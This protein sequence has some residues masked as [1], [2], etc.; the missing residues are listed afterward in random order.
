MTLPDDRPHRHFLEA[1]LDGDRARGMAEARVHLARGVVYLYERI[2]QPAMAEVGALWQANRITVADE[3]LAAATMQSVMASLY[4]DFPWP[5]AGPRALVAC[6]EGE[7]HEIGAR[8]FADLLALDGWLDVLLGA[9]T[10][11]DAVIAK[12][13]ETRPVL[14]ALSVTLPQ[15]VPIVHETVVRLRTVLPAVK[16]LVGGQAFAGVLQADA[17]V[18]ADAPPLSASGGVRAARQWKPAA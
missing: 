11:L 1:I 13:V 2:F 7:R 16:V 6:L 8:M 3:H 15:H 4:A 17:G 18:G 5:S 9:D 12:A 14:V 10:P